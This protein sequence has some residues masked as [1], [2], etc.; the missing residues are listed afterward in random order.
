MPTSK[1][2]V[3]DTDSLIN[4]H[5]H[6]GMKA[7]KELRRLSK[8]EKLK[9][10]EGVIRELIRGTDKLANFA[11]SEQS[12]FIV[13]INSTPSLKE[14]IKRLENQYGQKIAVGGRQYQGFWS[15]KAGQKAAD[16]QVVA[17]AKL[18]KGTAV[19]DDNAVKLACALENVP[20]ISWSEFAR[21]LGLIQP[22]QPSLNF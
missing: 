17:V 5:R 22:E 1:T 7:I 19:S 14:E 13:T 11:K 10:P 18:F 20:C 15:S 4:L 8:E 6:F 9:V 16:S 12:W 21:Q 2:Y 3:C